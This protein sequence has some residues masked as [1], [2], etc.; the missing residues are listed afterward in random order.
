M[1]VRTIAD[2]GYRL[3]EGS[4]SELTTSFDTL[5]PY[6]FGTDFKKN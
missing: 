1:Q 4:V 6:E 3:L 5:F 2:N